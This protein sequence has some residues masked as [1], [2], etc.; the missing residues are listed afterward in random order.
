MLKNKKMSKNTL[1]DLFKNL[2]NNFDTENPNLGHQERFLNKLKTQNSS[3]NKTKKNLWKPFIG[4]AASIAL[5]VSL[6]VFSPKEEVN[7]IDLASIS[8]EMAKVES[9]F[10]ASLSKELENL[11]SEEMPEYQELI[12]DALFELKV[13]EEDYN[14]LIFGLKEHP[15]DELILDAM[16]LNFQSRIDIIQDTKEKIEELN[17]INN[18]LLII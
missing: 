11:N 1:E 2:E 13:L 4:I 12:V 16:I 15:N 6:F 17:N 8:P 18:Q 7:T 5:L 10:M 14:Q 3:L 9:V